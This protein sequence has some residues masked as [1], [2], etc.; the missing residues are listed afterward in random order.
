MIA[1]W[2]HL[3]QNERRLLYLHRVLGFSIREIDRQGLMIPR[4][5]GHEAP[6]ASAS[7]L[8]RMLRRID[9][10]IRRR[11]AQAGDQ[12]PPAPGPPSPAG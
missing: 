9:R 5:R 6:R 1:A 7:S 11:A 2:P 12:P 10:S 4:E 3:H 8:R